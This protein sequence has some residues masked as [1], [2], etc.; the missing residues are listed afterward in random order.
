MIGVFGNGAATGSSTIRPI[1]F[2]LAA[3]ILIDAFV[4]RM[5][6]VPMVMT[7]FGDGS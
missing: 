2:A 4:V 7:L 5:T 6:L 3:G 1:A